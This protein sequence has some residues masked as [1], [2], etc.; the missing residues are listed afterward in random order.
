MGGL[1]TDYG[2]LKSY[3]K[4]FHDVWQQRPI[5]DNFGGIS[6]IHGFYLWYTLKQL[7]PDYVIESGVWKGQ[8]TWLIRQMCDDVTSF[9]ID[10]SNQQYVD[11]EV[12]YFDKDIETVI[13]SKEDMNGEG[14]IFFDDHVDPFQRIA[15]CKRLGFRH[16][17]FD[18]NYPSGN[19]ARMNKERNELN[20]LKNDAMNEVKLDGYFEFPPVFDRG[21][22]WGDRL[23]DYNTK[24]PLLEAVKEP[25]QSMYAV[26]AKDYTW[27]CYLEL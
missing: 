22:R 3:L 7:K 13:Q 16:I 8:S 25:Y 26:D 1:P 21:T 10:Y 11:D 12:V 17:L 4:E 27:F 18:D 23:S 19:N 24:P 2:T 20:S 6:S 9:D 14:L 5:Q 15:W